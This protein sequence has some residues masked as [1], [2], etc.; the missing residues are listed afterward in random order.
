[1]RVSFLFG[2]QVTAEADVVADYHRRSPAIRRAYAAAAAVVGPSEF[3]IA[4]PDETPEDQ[5]SRNALRHTALVLGLVDDLAEHGI[6]PDVVGGLSLGALIGACVAGAIERDELYAMLHHRR[7][8]PRP[9]DD[10]PEQG[11]ML[12]GTA[13]SDRPERY[14]G[15]DHPGVYLAVDTGPVDTERRSFVVSGYRSGLERLQATADDGVHMF[16]FPGYHGAFH[17]PLQQHAADFMEP[18][19]NT[20]TFRDPKV[21]ICSPVDRRTLTTAAE[22]REFMLGHNLMPA[23]Y[24]PLVEEMNS[25]GVRAGLV[26]GPGLP[27]PVVQ[28]FRVELFSEPSDFDRRAELRETLGGIRSEAV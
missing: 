3:D 20:M 13:V 2:G 19:I 15:P 12:I 14:Y 10:G 24:E 28:P 5:H 18:F 4:N 11:M 22:V 25:L 9:A 6:E 7:L 21:P 23:R 16:L 27:A 8:V 17:S 1:M 26:V